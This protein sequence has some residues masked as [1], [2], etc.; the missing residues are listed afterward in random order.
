M[1][2]PWASIMT[3][4]KRNFK[5]TVGENSLG[6]TALMKTI[7]FSSILRPHLKEGLILL[8]LEGSFWRN[9][10]VFSYYNQTLGLKSPMKNLRECV[11]TYVFFFL[12]TLLFPLHLQAQERQASSPLLGYDLSFSKGLSNLN[13]KKYPQAIAELKKALETKPDDVEASYYLGVAFNKSGE[14]QKAQALLE[15]VL[16]LDPRFEKAHFDLGIVEYELKNYPKALQHL[17]IAKKIDPDNALVHYYQGLAYHHRGDYQRSSI[18]FLRSVALA[19]ELGLTSHYYAGVGFYRRGLLEEAKDELQEVIR[20]DPTSEVAHSAQEF[21]KQMKPT[22]KESKPW[23]ITLS[24]AYQYDS[25][26]ILQPESSA[27]PS[28]ISQEGD[29]RF[30]LYGRGG[31]RFLETSHWSMGTGYDF[32]QSLHTKLNEFNVQNHGGTL[33][34]QYQDKGW[35]FRAP[36]RVSHALV[37]GNSFLTSHSIQPTLTVRQSP[38]LFLQFIYGFS[39]K[40]FVNAIPFPRNSDR[41]G[42]NHLAGFVQTIGF[43]KTGRLRFGYT[44]DREITGDLAGQSDWDYEGQKVFGTLRLPSPKQGISLD[45]AVDYVFQDYSWPNSNSANGS[46]RLDIIKTYSITLTKSLGEN[47]TAS[48]QYIYNNNYSNISVFDYDRNIISISIARVF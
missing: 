17:Q 25:N 23:N 43:S 32:Y 30:V 13:Q 2:L 27:L 41:D 18:L 20:I 10:L 37:D 7:L 29:N 48:I 8:Y 40:D 28:G 4:N 46:A 45:I 33:F 14:N 3:M 15:K 39:S 24:T 12:T 42:T 26:V 11:S 9:S 44:Y 47:G 19:P 38:K 34:I 31:Y 36:Y 22:T 1:H 35:Q 5:C 21:L 6:D 16:T